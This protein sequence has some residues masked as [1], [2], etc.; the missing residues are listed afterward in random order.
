MDMCVSGG[1]S[2]SE[3]QDEEGEPMEKQ[4]AIKV[5]KPRKHHN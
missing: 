4:Q 1:S 3:T 2:M 5:L